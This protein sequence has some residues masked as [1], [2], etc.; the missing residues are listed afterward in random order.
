MNK[1]LI[2]EKFN[3]PNSW[4]IDVLDNLTNLIIDGTHFT[5]NYAESGVP[6]LRV[7]DI[8]EDNIDFSRLKFITAA[9]HKLLTKRC[10]PERNDILYSKNGTIGIPKVVNWNWEF[11]VFVSL[12]LIKLDKT[13]LT[14]TYLKLILQ[15]DLIKWQIHRRAKQGTVT[16]LHLEE[17]R[18]LE[19]PALELSHQRK[20]ARIL[21]TVDNII[22]KTEATIAKYKAIKQGVMHDLFTRGIDVKT[23]KLF[24]TFEDA[25]ELYKP[26][27][28]GM[29]PK[30][31]EVEDF[32]TISDLITDFT[33]NGSFESLKLN[34]KYYYEPNYGRLVRLTDL[35]NNLANDGAYVDQE[36]F[37]YLR[38]SSLKTGDIMLAN[39]GEYTGFACQMPS[40]DYPCT[41]APN[42]F[43]IRVNESNNSIFCYYYM[44]FPE[45]INQVDNVCASS[46]TKLLN[47]TNFRALLLRKP[48]IN[49]QKLISEKLKALDT[50]IENENLFL[51]K[52]QKIKQGLMQDLLTGKKEVIPDPEDCKEL[53]D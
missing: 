37:E 41:I 2:V 4:K 39:V 31:W 5:P 49:E 14:P 3:L 53:E 17:I 28:L 21:T 1:S 34:V 46:A 32:E 19:V 51:A 40:V 18:E 44:R 23:G 33:A 36:G 10:K 6:F 27:E 52:N 47:K 22:E 48:K 13:K 16:N 38:K 30:D 20:I 26:S 50:K 45:F 35:R 12:C 9:E 42:M 15:S 11:S 25:P 43:L 24:P 29:I 7:T 8:Q